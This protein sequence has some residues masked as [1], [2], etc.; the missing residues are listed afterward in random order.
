MDTNNYWISIKGNHFYEDNTDDATEII[1]QGSYTAMNGGYE[2][3]YDETEPETGSITKTT[4]TIDP[5]HRITVVREGDIE[6]HMIFEQGQ[7]H[8]VHYDTEFGSI[9]IGVSASRVRYTLGEN[10]GD[11]S[12]DYALEIDNTVAT[13]NKL[14]M[15]VRE[16]A[17][18]S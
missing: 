9:T 13:E 3:V 11:I 16:V 17:H 18:V 5:Q 7:K 12:I 14:I 2:I 10:G 15:N 1:T 4:V 8:L 6:S